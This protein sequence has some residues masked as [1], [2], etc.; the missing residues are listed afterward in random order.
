MHAAYKRKDTTSSV[1][2]AGELDQSGSEEDD[3]FDV[4][5]LF[6]EAAGRPRRG[7]QAIQD[8]RTGETVRGE[9]DQVPLG[10]GFQRRHEGRR[11]PG[12]ALH[13]D[14]PELVPLRRST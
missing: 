2:T 4:G 14:G 6:D 11:V 9:R 1:S 7:N 13:A 8:T 3:Q 10:A 12:R 5:K